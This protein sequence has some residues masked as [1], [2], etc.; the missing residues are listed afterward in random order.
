LDLFGINTDLTS[1]IVIFFIDKYMGDEL[2]LFEMNVR[3][4]D[5]RDMQEK[6][7]S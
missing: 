1:G 3:E 6:I 7:P 5:E 4:S 2:R